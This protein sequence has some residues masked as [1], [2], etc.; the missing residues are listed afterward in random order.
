MERR[1]KVRASGNRNE[2]GFTLIELAV[3]MVV[4]GVLAGLAMPIYAR[5]R[6]NANHSHSI[7][8]LKNAATAAE[9]W[10]VTSD[11]SFEGLTYYEL[12]EEGF[13]DDPT[14]MLDVANVDG[15]GYCLTATNLEL[16]ASHDWRISTYDSLEMTPTT[17]DDCP[18]PRRAPV[19]AR[20]S[21]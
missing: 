5:T 6:Q 13:Q 17:V 14:V 21:P 8:T 20:V 7:S 12:V 18:T 9:S 2:H 19:L 11:G 1:T 15:T 3:A 16:P 10:A 4:I